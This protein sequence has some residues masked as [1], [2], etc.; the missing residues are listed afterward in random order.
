MAHEAG[1]RIDREAEDFFRPRAGDLFDIHAALG[2]GDEGEPRGR[3]VDQRGEIVFTVDGGAFL[4][5]EAVHLFA[6]RPGLVRDQRRAEQPLGLALHVGDRFHHLDAAGF[7]ASAG[8]DLRLH[9]PDRSAEFLGGL[10]G[11][12]DAQG[13][14]C[15][16]APA[17][18]IR[19]TR[20]S[21]GI[22]G[23]S[24]GWLKGPGRGPKREKVGYQYII[25][26]DREQ[27]SCRPRPSPAPPAP[28]SRTCRARRC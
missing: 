3:A 2:R 14:Q 22:R 11:L 15:R 20:L 12:L 19:A 5:V 21:P 10:D 13:R 4:D 25:C 8:V 26:R 18:R 27:S 7:A 17:R 28:I 1:R 16:A 9:H 6:V 23:C 24:C